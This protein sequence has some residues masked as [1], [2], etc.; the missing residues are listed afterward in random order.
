MTVVDSSIIL[1]ILLEEDGWQAH[2]AAL[3][4]DECSIAAPTYVEATIAAVGR[5]LPRFEIDDF[6]DRS[7]IRIVA[8][9]EA[10]AD[11]AVR[12]FETYGKG[13]GHKARLNFGDCLAYA[14]AKRLGAALLFKGDDFAHTDV[15]RA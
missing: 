14:A 9:D 15:A 4:S 6:L 7:G 10:A 8:F 13:R 5:G 12:A 11:L 1:A 2:V 3:V